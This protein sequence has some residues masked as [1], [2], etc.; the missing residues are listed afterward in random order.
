[1]VFSFLLQVL[2]GA[3]SWSYAHIKYIVLAL[4]LSFIAQPSHAV[5]ILDGNNQDQY[6]YIH[7]LEGITLKIVVETNN[8]PFAFLEGSASRPSG[9]DID[10]IYALQRLLGFEL[11]ENRF[12]P[13]STDVGFDLLDKKEA[14]LLIGGIVLN[15]KRNERFDPTNIVFSSGLSYI[16]SKTHKE[17]KSP[18]ALKGANVGV[19]PNSPAEYYVKSVLGGNT[20]LCSN[21]VMAF[22]NLV[23]GRLDAVVADRPSLVYF[24]RTMPVFDL[25]VSDAVFDIYSGQ[26]VF[27]MQKNSPYTKAF[28]LA[29]KALESNGTMYKLRKKWMTES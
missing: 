27:Y 26:F 8:A 18:G 22:Y 17:I 13:L 23:C 21:S 20:V 24:A 11:E 29:L 7:A 3:C 1:M 6:E 4:V 15:D 25:S 2:L 9:F 5:I 16:Y 12:Y 14:D 28:N 10:V 19:K